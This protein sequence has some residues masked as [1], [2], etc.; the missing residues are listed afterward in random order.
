MCN[1]ASFLPPLLCRVAVDYVV[2]SAMPFYCFGSSTARDALPPRTESRVIQLYERAAQQAAYRRWLGQEAPL[3][4]G[5]ENERAGGRA[6]L[7]RS[8]CLLAFDLVGASKW[9]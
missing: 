7:A 2:G 3:P 1:L 9:L 4:Q 5:E 6:P 8:S